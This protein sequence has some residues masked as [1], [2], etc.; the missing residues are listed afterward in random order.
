VGARKQTVDGWVRARIAFVFGF[1]LV[2][3]DGEPVD[4]AAFV[5]A[6]PNW[7]EG[8]LITLGRGEQLRVLATQPDIDERLVERG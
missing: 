3:R 4:P 8:E 1:L 7:S 5:T 6:V 2:D